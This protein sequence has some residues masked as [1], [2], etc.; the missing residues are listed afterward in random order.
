MREPDAG[1]LY[2]SEHPCIGSAKSLRRRTV[3]QYEDVS[4]RTGEA[5][6]AITRQALDVRNDVAS[7]VAD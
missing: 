5:I 6:G 4:S 1:G 3:E 2:R 7:A